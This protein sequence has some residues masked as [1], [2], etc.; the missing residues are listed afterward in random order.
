MLAGWSPLIAMDEYDASSAFWRF[1]MILIAVG[2]LVAIWALLRRR[3]APRTLDGWAGTG[4]GEDLSALQAGLLLR[5]HPSQLVT[6]ALEPLLDSGAVSLVSVDPLRLEWRDPPAGESPLAVLAR[7]LS[8]EGEIRVEGLWAFLEALQTEVNERLEPHSGRESAIHF[9]RLVKRRW[10]AALRGAEPRPED[11]PWLLLQDPAV[12]IGR[13]P[14][15]PTGERLHD[16]IR[17]AGVFRAH[18]VSDRDLAD[19][20]H[21]ASEGY[22]RHRRDLDLVRTRR[23]TRQERDRPEAPPRSPIQTKLDAL[24]GALDGEIVSENPALPL[25]LYYTEIEPRVVGRHRGRVASVLLGMRDVV[26]IDLTCSAACAFRVAALDAG[27]KGEIAPGSERVPSGDSEFDSA[28]LATQEGCDDFVE[29][30]AFP[31]MRSLLEAHGTII[32]LI[33]LPTRL[34]L[35]FP[36]DRDRFTSK[37]ILDR[38]AP[39]LTFAEWIEERRVASGAKGPPGNTAT[40][41]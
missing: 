15:G 29:W 2:V 23:G 10:G 21:N 33:G 41:R 7:G 14:G 37:E 39:M 31:R 26:T 38:F 25:L 9:R 36:Y 16:L 22:F 19:R 32:D 12:V 35:R 40:E 5:V 34:V 28:Y 17:L 24:S 30:M 3:W 4:V 18:L 13:I 20:A 8:E 11:R 27:E 6:V 1:I